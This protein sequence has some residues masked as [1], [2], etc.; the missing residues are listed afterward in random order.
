MKP[1]RDVS[2]DGIAADLS[3]AARSKEG[4]RIAAVATQ[5]RIRIKSPLASKSWSVRGR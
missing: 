5:A 1:D 2:T 4:D 3:F